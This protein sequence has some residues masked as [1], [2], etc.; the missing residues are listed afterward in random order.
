MPIHLGD[1]PGEFR[2]IAEQ[3]GKRR[4]AARLE[5]HPI[6]LGP[7]SPQ[8]DAF[9]FF[10]IKRLFYAA[11]PD[12]LAFGSRASLLSTAAGRPLRVAPTAIY[13]YL[14]FGFVPAADSIFQVAGLSGAGAIEAACATDNVIGIGVDVDQSK[15]LSGDVSCVLTS[16]EKGTGIKAL[17][18][19]LAALASV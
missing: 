11:G 13:D 12:G 1:V 6:L 9:E 3:G 2:S 10:G 16:A 14:N 7:E 8:I 18:A 19:D 15:S 17:R 5:T 4:L